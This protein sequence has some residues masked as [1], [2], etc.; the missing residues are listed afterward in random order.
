MS[1]SVSVFGLAFGLGR[2]VKKVKVRKK[3]KKKKKF[4]LILVQWEGDRQGAE[5][6]VRDVAVGGWVG[7]GWAG[8]VGL[9]ACGGE[10]S[11][12]EGRLV[13]LCYAP[14]VLPVC[15]C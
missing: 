6:R 15:L 3:E 12:L 1:V 13:G 9:T 7:L 8:L 5:G 2:R 10:I 4:N 14:P 11:Y